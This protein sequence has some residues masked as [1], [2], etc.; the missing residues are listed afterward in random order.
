M[1]RWSLFPLLPNVDQGVTQ[2]FAEIGVILLMFGVGLHFS[3]A[4]LV[5]EGEGRCRHGGTSS[6]DDFGVRGDCG[7]A[8]GL[9][10]VFAIGDR[11]WDDAVVR[12]DRGG[13]EG[14]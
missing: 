12:L 13:D 8:F 9:E 6:D 10:L 11:L 1:W 7:R 3:V 4:D 5:P 2:Q 14:P